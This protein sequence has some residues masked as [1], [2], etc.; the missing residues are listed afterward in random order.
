MDNAFKYVINYGGLCSEED[1]P[2]D[3]DQGMC[4]S[5]QC[6]NVVEITDYADVEPNNEKIL[7]R[8]T[9]AHQPI[10]VKFIQANLTSF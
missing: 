6:K 10:S 2:Y 7:K 9:V 3:A 1:Y 5:G 4:Q 8:A